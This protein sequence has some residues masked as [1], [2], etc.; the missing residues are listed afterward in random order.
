MS[1]REIY[2]TEFDLKRLQEV[3][4]DSERSGY[5]GSEYVRD[6]ER[7]LERGKVVAPTDVPADVVTMNSLVCLEDLDTQEELTYRLVFP[8]EA[9]IAENRISILAPIGTAMLGYR[10]GDTFT[11]DVPCGVRRLRVKKIL[12]QPEAAGDYHL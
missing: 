2:I 9:D 5:A 12:Y 1:G 4:E 7:E 10:V 8:E 3:I 11:W 6:L